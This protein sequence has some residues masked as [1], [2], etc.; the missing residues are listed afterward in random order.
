MPRPHHDD[1]YGNGNVVMDALLV[2]GA[3]WFR[4]I[5]RRLVWAWDIRLTLLFGFE[6]IALCLNLLLELPT[7]Y[8]PSPD[9][10]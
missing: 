9:I 4:M 5:L 1:W 6:L 2:F 10:E 3:G 8:L 7:I